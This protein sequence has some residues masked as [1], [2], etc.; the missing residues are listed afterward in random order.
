MW[1]NQ[2]SGLNTNQY[3]LNFYLKDIETTEKIFEHVEKFIRL[4]ENLKP[5]LTHR[6]KPI[7]FKKGEIVLNADS[8]CTKS[9]FINKGILRTYFLKDEKEISEYFCGINEWVNSPKSFM[10]RT[11]DIYFIDTIEDTE[12]YFIS[13]D[14]L[15]YFFDNY[16]EMERYA[17]LSMGSVL[18]I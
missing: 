12:T 1:K 9:Y 2:I 15:V 11:K 5:E 10:Q 3:E 6:L 18:G 4:S 16:P 13:V 17:R 7:V 14:D 8:V